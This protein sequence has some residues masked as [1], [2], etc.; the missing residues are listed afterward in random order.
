MG[1]KDNGRE[2]SE[3]EGQ[4]FLDELDAALASGRAP[5]SEAR[6]ELAVGLDLREAVGRP[7]SEAV[8]RVAAQALAGSRG[9]SVRE[10]K[11]LVILAALG[12]MLLACKAASL[13]AGWSLVLAAWR[14]L[15]PVLTLAV[16]ALLKSNPF[17]LNAI[18]PPEGETR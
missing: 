17:K 1:V 7:A 3:A 5:E 6:R 12:L 11:M 8:E 4:R 14:L 9:T 18:L 10:R 16:F 2:L 13:C 15:P